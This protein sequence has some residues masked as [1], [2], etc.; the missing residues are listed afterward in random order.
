ML[1]FTIVTG[2]AIVF[3]ALW[4][5]V[6]KWGKQNLP[7][8]TNRHFSGT[9]TLGVKAATSRE[10]QNLGNRQP[11]FDQLFGE[12]RSFPEK[13]LSIPPDEGGKSFHQWRTDQDFT[14]H[15]V[16]RRRTEGRR[17]G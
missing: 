1:K 13:E 17:H 3:L 12:F 14:Q 6:S 11:S 16:M 15:D 10:T 7:S 2:G 5:L 9:P 8:S 4:W